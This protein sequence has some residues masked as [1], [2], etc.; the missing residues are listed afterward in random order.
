MTGYV[1]RP[2]S[3]R[4]V[5]NQQA[6]GHGH[7]HPMEAWDC[8]GDRLGDLTQFTVVEAEEVLAAR[9]DAAAREA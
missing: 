3:W 6:C 1:A 5:V 8:L 9:I 2:D 7:S 4:S